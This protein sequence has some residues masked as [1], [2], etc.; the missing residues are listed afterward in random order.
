MAVAAW[1][2]PTPEGGSIERLRIVENNLLLLV[3]ATGA[4]GLAVP[5]V[6]QALSGA[7]TLLLAVL[8]FAVSLSFDV[9]ALRVILRR[10][11]LPLLATVLVYV[12]MS[13]AAVGIATVVF[14]SGPLWLGVILLGV[15]PTDVSSPL[16]VWIGR[17]NVAL[18]TVFNA[19]NT[20]LAPVLVPLLFL[21]Y[22]G[23]DLDVPVGALVL[24]LALTVLLPTIAGVAIRTWQPGP[25]QRIEPALSATGALSYLGLLL[26]VVGPNADAIRAAPTTMLLLTAAGLALNL[27]GYAIALATRPLVTSHHDRVAMLF[28][29]SKKEF[30]IAAV[31]VFASGLPAEVALPA[32]IYAVVQMVTSPI[33]ANAAARRAPSVHPHTG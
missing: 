16:L 27:T 31:V 11:G 8:M 2:A 26:A 3:L 9:A 12:P 7:V 17:G 13:L 6:G 1:R 30:S 18:A 4:V 23:I 32:V 29:V 14:G 33:V 19:V 21:T 28:T 20:A 25:I 22:T 15:L 5:Q 10:P 24:E